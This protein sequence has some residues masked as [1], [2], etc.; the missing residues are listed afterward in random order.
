[1]SKRLPNKSSTGVLAANASC[2][3]HLLAA[4]VSKQSV[5]SGFPSLSQ[6]QH[7]ALAVRDCFLDVFQLHA[8]PSKVRAMTSKGGIVSRG[9]LIAG[10]SALSSGASP[11]NRVL[12]FF[13]GNGVRIGDKLF[14]V[15][16][17]NVLPD[18]LNAL[19]ELGQV[20]EIVDSSPALQKLVILDVC[21]CGSQSSHDIAV[22]S[23]TFS[24]K[25][26]EEYL[27]HAKTTAVLASSSDSQAVT[28]RSPNPK[29][30]LFSYHLEAALRGDSEALTESFLTLP[31]LF[32]S[33]SAKV[34]R[35]SKAYKRTQQPI[36]VLPTSDP[37]VFGDF[38]PILNPASFSVD[39]Y[40]IASLQF[41]DWEPMEAK[42][43][44]TNNKRWTYSLEHI[45][46]LVNESLGTHLEER[47]GTVVANLRRALG[48]SS[49]DVAV[50]GTQIDFPDGVYQFVYQADHAK[51]GRLMHRIR[52]GPGWFGRSA[53]VVLVLEAL[54]LSP[55]EV[56]IEMIASVKP[57][58]LVPGLQAAGWKVSSELPRK[59]EA[60]WQSFHLVV[61][62]SNL[63]FRGFSASELLAGPTKQAAVAS[64]VMALLEQ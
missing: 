55:T 31:K 64:G 62:P 33:V 4:G 7:D 51:H 40:P 59:L 5:S 25:F 24:K 38:R 16:E 1:L 54:S 9:G 32:D 12:F 2:P 21:W 19:L 41:S 23:S 56:R 6:C 61:E 43:V 53:E 27:R 18:D 28:T 11:S 26:L 42:D 49:R 8:E 20:L 47:L 52:F 30:S 60:E 50:A 44:L 29:L 34:R 17:D 15:P 37:F 58:E 35:D 22:L 63:T 36:L 39:R 57:L 46:G 45:A 10:L 3:L 14:L 48:F 13:S